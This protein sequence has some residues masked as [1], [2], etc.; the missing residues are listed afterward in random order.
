MRSKIGNKIGAF[1]DVH[2]RDFVDTC[3][4]MTASK[5]DHV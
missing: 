5:H 4:Y 2:H 1:I 3:N